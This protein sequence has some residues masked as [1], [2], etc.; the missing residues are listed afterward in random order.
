MWLLPL[1]I[2]AREFRG[3]LRGC[4]LGTMLSRC[5][6]ASRCKN[7]LRC[8]HRA[9]ERLLVGSLSQHRFFRVDQRRRKNPLHS[10]EGLLTFRSAQCHRNIGSFSVAIHDG[11]DPSAGWKSRSLVTGTTQPAQEIGITTAARSLH[12]LAIHNE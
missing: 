2:A 5:P 8:K 4:V 1:L 11:C 3:E 12:A 6:I 7:V 10:G 9:S